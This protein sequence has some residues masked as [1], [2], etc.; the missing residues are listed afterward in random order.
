MT[1]GLRGD[2]FAGFFGEQPVGLVVL[3]AGEG[4]PGVG[5]QGADPPTRPPSWASWACFKRSFAT[6]SF[7]LIFRAS[8]RAA[9]LSS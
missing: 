8:L 5:D 3:L 2:S 9:M 7:G 6:V 4:L 1:S